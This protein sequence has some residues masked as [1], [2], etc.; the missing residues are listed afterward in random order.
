LFIVA[1][2]FMMLAIVEGAPAMVLGMLVSGA[3]SRP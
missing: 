1:A 2:H 3:I